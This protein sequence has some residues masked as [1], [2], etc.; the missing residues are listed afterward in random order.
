VNGLLD[1]CPSKREGIDKERDGENHL[2]AGV[3]YSEEPPTVERPAQEKQIHFA[4]LFS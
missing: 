2:I 3:F 4:N 1:I